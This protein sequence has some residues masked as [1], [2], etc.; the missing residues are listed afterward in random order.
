MAAPLGFGG[1]AW[2]VAPRQRVKPSVETAR[3]ASRI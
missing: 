3:E 1:R 2:D